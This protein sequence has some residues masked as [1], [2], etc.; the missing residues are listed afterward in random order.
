MILIFYRYLSKKEIAMTQLRL[1][2]LTIIGFIMLLSCTRIPSTVAFDDQLSYTEIDGYRFH[3][4]TFG[5]PENPVIIV[6]HGGPGGDY[7]Y[8]LPLQSLAD[9]YFIV[10]YDQRGCGLSPRVEDSLLTLEQNLEDLKNI[11][12]YFGKGNPV[13]VI[14]HSWGGMLGVAL[15]NQYPDV[16]HTL[17]AAEPGILH[18]QAAQAFAAD[19]EEHQSFW[20]F[21]VLMRHM[22]VYPFVEKQDGHEGYDYVMT[23]ILNRNKPGPPYNCEGQQMPEDAFLRGGFAAFNQMLRP[24]LSDPANFT[25]DLTSNIKSY[26]GQLL[27]LSSEC[28]FLGFDYQEKHHLL[29]MPAQTKHLMVP[30]TGHNMITMESESSIRAIRDFLQEK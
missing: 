1:T 26:R 11:A 24:T 25:W 18:P 6:V 4:E 12:L 21:F 19:L 23:K 22:V 14:G 28:S 30:N 15:A 8:L 7:R 10:F 9:E 2:S 13:A 29:K 16:V 17:V 5:E 20:D 27:F 3:T